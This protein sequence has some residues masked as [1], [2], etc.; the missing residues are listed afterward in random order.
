[1]IRIEQVTKSYPLQGFAR[2]YVFRDLSLTLPSRTHIGIVGRNGAGKSTLLRL[3]GGMELPEQG[4][5]TA[6][7]AISPPLGLSGGFA[8]R[9][10]GRDNARFVCRVN[11]DDVQTIDERVAF[12][13]QFAELGEFFDRPMET[14][15][16]GMRARVAF[17]IS[18]AFEYDYYL[19]DELTAVGDQ[20]FREKAQAAFN[21]KKGRASVVMVSHN[22]DQ[23][24]RDCQVGI[25]MKKD[26]PVFYDDIGKAVADYRKDQQAA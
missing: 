22:L 24:K 21:E 3:I 16:S 12:I 26:G 8:V 15:S 14:Y 1:M 11:G 2:Y 23:L 4:R 13:E 6:D 10:S 17:A 7:G 25:Y 18:M 19:I 9:L 20:K 5:I